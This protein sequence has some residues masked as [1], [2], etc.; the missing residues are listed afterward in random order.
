MYNRIPP[1][2]P[3]P[4]PKDK[5][6]GLIVGLCIAI[7]VC[8]FALSL[9]IGILAP[10]YLKYVEKSRLYAD[11]D[12]LDAIYNS[13]I[14]ASENPNVSVS[15]KKGTSFTL[16]DAEDDEDLKDWYKEV[17]KLMEV[18]SISDI[19]FR[20]KEAKDTP[21]YIQIDEKGKISSVVKGNLTIPE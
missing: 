7:P 9:L 13:C 2:A 1:Y 19:E 11:K 18:D 20:S 6:I 17:C 12:M 15:F 4:K 14:V 3:V 16:E 21:I 5:G 10:Q 8:L